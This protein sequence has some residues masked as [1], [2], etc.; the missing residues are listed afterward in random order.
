MSLVPPPKP[1]QRLGIG[2]PPADIHPEIMRRKVHQDLVTSRHRREE[3]GLLGP[4][5]GAVLEAVVFFAEPVDLQV[6]VGGVVV[7]VVSLDIGSAADAARLGRE[8]SSSDRFARA[9]ADA[10][11]VQIDAARLLGSSAARRPERT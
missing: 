8:I 4:R 2:H 3:L 7:E 9:G 6:R 1:H 10:L 5:P 11:F